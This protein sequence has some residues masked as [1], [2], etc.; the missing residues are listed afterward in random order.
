MKNLRRDEDGI[1]P[2]LVGITAVGALLF[3][4][5][6]LLTG[7]DPVTALMTFLKFALISS[8]IFMFGILVLMKKLP[9]L[10]PPWDF[11]IGIGSIAGAIYI[12]WRYLI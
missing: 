7:D 4:G 10:M 6:Y 8:L 3:G 5:S 1:I 9:V 11:I 2:L 12:A